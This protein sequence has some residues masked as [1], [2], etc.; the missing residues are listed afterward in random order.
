MTF[1]PLCW[2]AGR[3]ARAEGARRIRDE[4]EARGFSRRQ[5]GAVRLKIE[6]LI[7]LSSEEE[8]AA[9]PATLL[10]LPPHCFC[11]N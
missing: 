4:A 7:C 11:M 3:D 8:T 1:F 5:V 2:Q 6:G 9:A 10:L